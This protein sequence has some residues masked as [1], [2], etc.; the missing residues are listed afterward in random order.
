M[1]AAVIVTR[2]D[3]SAVHSYSDENS[4]FVNITTVDGLITVGSIYSRPRGNL[5]T[6]MNWLNNFDP[7]QNIIIG[8]DLNVHLTMQSYDNDDERGQILSYLLMSYN[9][10][11]VND[12]E[13]PLIFH[14]RG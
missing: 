3:I 6:D 1:T 4:V 2:R 13:A 12:T 9:L 8:A 11:L 14:R 5:V 7:L 10:T